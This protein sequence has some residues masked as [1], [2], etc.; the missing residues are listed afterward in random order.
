MISNARTPLHFAPPRV[1]FLK[2][3]PGQLRIKPSLAIGDSVALKYW[4]EARDF[5]FLAET[6]T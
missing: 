6:G 4:R 2:V 1:Q 5:D 3:N